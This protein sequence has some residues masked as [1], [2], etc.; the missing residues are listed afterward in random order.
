MTNPSPFNIAQTAGNKFGAQI[1]ERR[2]TKTITEILDRTKG[3]KDPQVLQDAITDIIARVSPER[4]KTA[5][6]AL[7]PRLKALHEAQKPDKGLTLNEGLNQAEK[8]L[9]LKIGNITRP[10]V[11]QDAFGNMMLDFDQADIDRA[12]VLKQ[13]D[14]ETGNWAKEVEEQYQ[15]RGMRVPSDLS[16]MFLENIQVNFQGQTTNAA[17]VKFIGEFTEK[18]PPAKHK[19]KQAKD[20]KGNIIESDGKEWI[21][22]EEGN[23]VPANQ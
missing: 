8:R 6:A 20:A 10:F 17:T 2:E 16:S 14:D 13:I 7:Q 21:I 4:G 11:K 15:R 3:S 18:Y 22:V 19:G 12:K 1:K 23:V 9:K 5:T